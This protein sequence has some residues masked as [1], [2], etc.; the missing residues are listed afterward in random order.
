MGKTYIYS[1]EPFKA[2]SQYTVIDAKE[3]LNIVKSNLVI[4]ASNG[5]K[6]DNYELFKIMYRV[7]NND[8]KV[9]VIGAGLEPAYAKNIFCL[10]V[11][12]S[13]RNIYAVDNLSMIDDDYIES[14]L[15][16]EGTLA[17]LENYVG[18][19]VVFAETIGTILLE[20]IQRCKEGDDAGLL[21]YIKM[22]LDVLQNSSYYNECM[23]SVNDKLAGELTT[24][25]TEREKALTDNRA[26]REKVDK[27]DSKTK[28]LEDTISTYKKDITRLQDENKGLVERLNS[29]GPIVSTFQSLHTG[30]LPRARAKSIMYIKE[31]SYVRYVNSLISNII[32]IISAQGGRLKVK[33][34]VYDNK[35]DFSVIYKPLNIV[36]WHDYIQNKERLK[37]V[38]TLVVVEPNS[39][40]LEDALAEPYDLVI[41][42]DRLKLQK[43]LVHGNNVFKYWVINSKSNYNEIEGEVADQRYIITRPGVL[44]KSIAIPEIAGYGTLTPAAKLAKYRA[45]QNAAEDPKG[46]IVELMLQRVGIQ[47]QGRR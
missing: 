30:T 13:I 2:G 39:V 27:A 43:D 36:T 5:A 25:R 22:N 24:M 7:V 34:L 44:D 32:S 16:K 37:Q 8:N 47:I 35:S 4:I 9:Y 38:T 21:E 45:L 15:A 46:F 6:I 40:I 33:M 3:A 29:S 42:Y 31:V 17:D 20:I 12:K 1:T 41:V 18:N 10:A 11:A 28:E 26:M 23:R 14:I 19:D